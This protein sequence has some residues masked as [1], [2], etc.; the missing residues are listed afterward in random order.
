MTG[1]SRIHGGVTSETLHGGYQM[2]IL[3]IAANSSQ[4]TA[5][6]VDGTTGAI[7]EGGFSRAIRAIQTIAT[8]VYI[9]T[10]ANGQFVVA[11]DGAT[12]QPTGPAY[13]TDGSP[14]VTE[15]IKAVLE[16]NLTDLTLTAT[17]TDIS[18]L[19]AGNLA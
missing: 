6:S 18:G 2:T 19:V 5:D 8:T 16:A 15:R 4:F 1:I 7:T 10:R 12:A 9:G 17:V 13:D 3:K 11:V 14:T